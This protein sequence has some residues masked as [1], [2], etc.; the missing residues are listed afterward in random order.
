MITAALQLL[1]VSVSVLSLG[2]FAYYLAAF[3][4]S[5]LKLFSF[6]HRANAESGELWAKAVM[7]LSLLGLA[8]IVFAGV[9]GIL[10]WMPPSWGWRSEEEWSTL[11][12]WLTF[13]LGVCFTAGLALALEEATRARAARQQERLEKSAPPAD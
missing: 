12:G 7:A 5:P 4:I 9:Y 2:C 13:I 6:G 1:A 10:W 11:R 3:A 8:I